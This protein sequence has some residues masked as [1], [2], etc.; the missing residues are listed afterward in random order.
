MAGVMQ[1][2]RGPTIYCVYPHSGDI[3][4]CVHVA[5]CVCVCV[6]VCVCI[7]HATP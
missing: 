4:V 2:I 6:C 7:I 1:Y 5:T 3:C